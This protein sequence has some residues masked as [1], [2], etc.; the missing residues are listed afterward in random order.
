MYLIVSLKKMR[1]E[2]VF[3]WICEREDLY[4]EEHVNNNKYPGILFKLKEGYGAGWAIKVPIF[5]DTAAHSFFPGSHLGDMPIFFML[6]LGDKKCVKENVTLMDI[7]PMVLDISD[8]NGEFDFG[9]KSIF[10]HKYN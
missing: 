3:E 4:A 6:N 5:S 7:A 9:G 2:K 8:V 1:N 10:K